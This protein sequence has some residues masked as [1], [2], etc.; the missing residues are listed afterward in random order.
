MR[1]AKQYQLYWG[2]CVCV[3]ARR[4]PGR[5]AY[6]AYTCCVSPAASVSDDPIT[7]SHPVNTGMEET[8]NGQD[9]MY[10]SLAKPSINT[11]EMKYVFLG[12]SVIPTMNLW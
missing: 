11:M 5:H 1:V 3:C 2:V 8:N 9:L 6:T 12:K 10:H 4:V 7:I